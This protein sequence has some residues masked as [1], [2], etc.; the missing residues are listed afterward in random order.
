MKTKWSLKL[1][2]IEGLIIRL[3]CS[4]LNKLSFLYAFMDVDSSAEMSAPKV[5]S[6]GWLTL[7]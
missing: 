4:T 6:R 1:E 3:S 2:R 5:V 7:F